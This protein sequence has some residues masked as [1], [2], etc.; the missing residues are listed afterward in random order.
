MR[1]IATVLLSCLGLTLAITGPADAG[2]PNPLEQLSF[3]SAQS[4]PIADDPANCE[5]YLIWSLADAGPKGYSFTR[6]EVVV[7]PD[8]NADWDTHTIYA[9]TPPEGPIRFPL[10]N[11]QTWYFNVRAT[12]VK[13]KGKYTEA[14]S[15]WGEAYRVDVAC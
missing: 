5:L 12:Y 15:P 1:R 6:Y 14:H 13:D 3:S 7:D 9:Y 8:P 4:T 10:T 2:K 11:N